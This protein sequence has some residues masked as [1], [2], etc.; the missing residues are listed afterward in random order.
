MKK[1]AVLTFV[2]IMA[3]AFFR[4]AMAQQC[5]TEEII[6]TVFASRYNA[7]LH[8]R[9]DG[10][11]AQSFVAAVNTLQEM[12][13]NVYDPYV[14]TVLFYTAPGKDTLKV[15]YMAASGCVIQHGSIFKETYAELT[16]AM[17]K[18]S[19]DCDKPGKCV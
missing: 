8:A 16:K 15:F 5:I 12:E 17:K 7:S 13:A 11:E 14:V 19:L 1:Y 4:P 9:F 10:Q 3:L 6:S 2:A 18:A